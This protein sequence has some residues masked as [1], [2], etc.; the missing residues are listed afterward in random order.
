VPDSGFVDDVRHHLV[1]EGWVTASARVR[2]EAAVVRAL[3]EDGRGPSRVLV[4]VVDDP[5]GAV[6]ADHVKYLVR[7]AEEKDAG[8][9]LLTSLAEVTDRAHRAADARDVAVV[10]PSIFRDDDVETTIL[11]ILERDADSDPEEAVGAAG[12]D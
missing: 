7:G 8:A 11:E 10:A 2:P 9:T 1:K 12:G 4:M 6:L 5:D 3:R